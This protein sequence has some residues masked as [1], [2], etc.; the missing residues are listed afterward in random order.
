MTRI[1]FFKKLM[2]FTLLAIIGLLVL[3]LSRKIITGKDCSICPGKGICRGETD[4]SKF[5]SEP[6]TKPVKA[7][8]LQKENGFI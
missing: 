7:P 2:R 4:C 3:A 1:E 8:L 6:A 5:N